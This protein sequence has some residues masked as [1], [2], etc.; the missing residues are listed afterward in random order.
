MALHVITVRGSHR[1]Y[2]VPKHFRL[3]EK[4]PWNHQ[5]SQPTPPPSIHNHLEQAYICYRSPCICL[6]WRFDVNGIIQRIAFGVWLL[7]FSTKVHPCC[8]LGQC[9]TPFCDG[10]TFHSVDGPQLSCSWSGC[11]PSCFAAFL[12]IQYST[13]AQEITASGPWPWPATLSIWQPSQ[14]PKFRYGAHWGSQPVKC[15]P[16][17]IS[18]SGRVESVVPGVDGWADSHQGLPAWGW[19]HCA[20]LS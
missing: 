7:S 18:A 15:F 17:S 1:L 10:V 12:C 20:L 4:K 14:M 16:V 5:Q 8:H 11:P 19:A 3:P 6:F 13:A 2:L 9:F